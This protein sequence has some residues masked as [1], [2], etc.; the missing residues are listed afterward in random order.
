ML[1]AIVGDIIG[2]PYRYVNAEDKFFDLAKGVRGWSHGHEVTFHPR[3]TDE[4]LLTMAAAKWLIQDEQ[5]RSSRLISQ[6]Q[7]TCAAYAEQGF[8]PFMQKW[9]A[10]DNPRASQYDICS[11]LS[12][13]IPAAMAARTL[14]EAIAISRQVT[15]VFS[16]SPQSAN[17]AMALGQA[18]WMAGHGRSK[19]DI[20][21]AMQNDFGLK[22][23]THQE[24]LSA[25][26]MGA[27]REPV[28]VNGEE[29]GEF[30]LRESGRMSRDSEVLVSAALQA[31][32]SGDG[33]EDS[34]R[35][36]VAL[37]GPSDT[38][39]S[40][41]GALAERFHG[42]VP[43][44]IKGACA[45]YIPTDVK[46]TVRS[47]EAI[48]LGKGQNA[49]AA[50]K[51]PDNSFNI[52]R[53]PDGSR[54]FAVPSY[55]TD[56]I[57]ALKERFGDNITIMKPSEA[58]QMIR[59]IS[60]NRPG[61]TYLEQ[62]RAD[63]RTLYFQDG[64]IKTSATLQGAHLPPIE[65]RIASRQMLCEIADYASQ[66]KSQLQTACGYTGEGNI[67][68]ENAYYPVILHDK[69]EVWKGDLFAGSVGIDP[70]SGLLKLSHGG[71]FGPMEWFGE[72][73]D[74]VFNSLN[75]D[76]MKQALGNYCLDEGRGIYDANRPLNKEVA[77]EDVARSKDTKF[78]AA[79][80]SQ[81]Q[82]QKMSA[83]MKM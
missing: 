26:L 51:Q 3:I 4:S 41:T 30:Y 61:G 45:T 66:V 42:S 17:A 33:F 46:N 2:S 18:L 43:E 39:A 8:S 38:V 5:H 12:C 16:T 69:V 35:R 73:T 76:S 78:Q 20:S 67:H 72:R 59:D 55:R 9:I 34:V 64:D 22:M 29:T 19:E 75:M 32:L 53:H 62:G 57:N 77:N 1:G 74:S 10:S 56:I 37:G 13:V 81:A 83:G 40:L 49:K 21:F 28:I 50:P 15:E 11:A 36:A 47:Y 58:Q 70:S 71:D 14:P 7:S 79:I 27:T 60:E 25:M 65:D 52:I 23:D 31:F 6:V 44:K 80:E 63:V 48:C 24:E 82:T 68:F 54:I